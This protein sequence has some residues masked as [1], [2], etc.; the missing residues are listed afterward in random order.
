MRELDQ[1][2][3][4]QEIEVTSNEH[5]GKTVSELTDEL[6]EGCHL[7]LISRNEANRLPEPDD[8]IE[9]GDHLTFIGRRE[10]VRDAIAYVQR[11]T[12]NT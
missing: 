7:A 5:A 1:D 11:N 8:R 6:S 10:A 9:I 4:V 3:D 2:G 12:E